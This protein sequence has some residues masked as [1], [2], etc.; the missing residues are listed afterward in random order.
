MKTVVVSPDGKISVQNGTR[1]AIMEDEI[2]A[3]TLSCGLCGTDLLK[4]NL[5]LLK[6]PTVLGHEW[7]GEICKAG[8][9]VK[10]FAMGDR[11]VAAHHAPC[12]DCHYCRHDAHSMCET[13]KKTNFV[14]GGFADYIVLSG[15]HLKHVTFK[16][17]KTM[18]LDEAIFTEPLACCLRS[19]NRLNLKNGDTVV[20]V[21]LG[22]I[23][24]MMAS[25]LKR[26]DCK[27]IGVDLDETRCEFAKQFGVTG[28]FTEFD[29]DFFK[30]LAALTG[31]RMADGVIFTAG[32]ATLLDKSLDWIR[33]GGFVNLFSHLSG[34]V[35]PIDTSKLY[36]REI[37]ILTSY[38]SSPD[39][40]KQAF[41][42]L[43]DEDLQLRRMFAPVYTPEKFAQAVD[44][45]NARRIYKALIGFC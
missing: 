14:P 23:G 26:L 22:S 3:R 15:L 10:N 17:P 18:P 20:I 8:K 29:T 40:L 39:T 1:P 36:H 9:S 24:L 2:L 42:I 37:Q 28:T 30:Q 34:E 33:G 19:V 12:F 25:L 35:G 16:I 43:K 38:S 4:I 11:I 32:P 13:F 5:G 45:V 6:K 21:G 31:N 7:V 41:E 27:M 44:D